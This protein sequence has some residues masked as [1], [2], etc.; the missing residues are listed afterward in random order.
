MHQSHHALGYRFFCRIYEMSFQKTN[1]R[2]LE[3][4]EQEPINFWLLMLQLPSGT[5]R[6]K[7]TNTNSSIFKGSVLWLHVTRKNFVSVPLS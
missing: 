6:F 2:C 1:Q 3:F 5:L 4:L 7:N